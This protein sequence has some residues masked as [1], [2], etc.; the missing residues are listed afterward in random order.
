CMRKVFKIFLYIIGSILVLLIGVIV[1]LNTPS[2]KNFVRAKVEAF[3]RKKLKTEVYIGGLGYGLPKYVVLEGVLFKDQ[4]K[5]TLLAVGKLKVDLDML[6]LI[7]KEVDVQE[8]LLEDVH[9]HV[10]RN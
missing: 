3:L 6:K 7:H 2:G 5:D 10:Y 4:Q 9:A 1:W 8:L